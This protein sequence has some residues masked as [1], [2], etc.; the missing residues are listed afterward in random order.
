M[1]NKI[2][3]IKNKSKNTFIAPILL[4]KKKHK[5]CIASQT[6]KESIINLGSDALGI[7]ALES[8]KITPKQNESIR[9]LLVKKFK[10]IAI[11]ITHSLVPVW[12]V[13]KK[14]MGLRMGKG[15]GAVSYWVNRLLGGK[16]SLRITISNV[17]ESF[18]LLKYTYSAISKRFNY[19]TKLVVNPHFLQEKYNSIIETSNYWKFTL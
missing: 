14:A 17:L 19:T 13:S 12:P 2:M 11:S 4:F 1:A 10:E 6:Y 3:P 18:N 15:K 8:A 9:R 5:N 7:K 16:I